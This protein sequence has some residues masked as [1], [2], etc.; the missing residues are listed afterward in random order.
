MPTRPTHLCPTC[1]REITGRC[2]H[3]QADY[4][5]RRQHQRDQ[6]RGSP[7]RRGY[8]PLYQ[9]NRKRI[10][11]GQPHC[12]WQ[13]PGCTGRATTADHVVTLAAGGTSDLDNLVPACKHCNSARTANG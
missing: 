9:T 8:G 13:L 11:K 1:Q 10:L 2:P 6:Q 5:R 3:C 12:A 7:T 4:R